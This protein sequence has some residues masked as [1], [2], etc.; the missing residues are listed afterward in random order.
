MRI[1]TVRQVEWLTVN[2][3]T[4]EGVLPSRSTLFNF[5]LSHCQDHKLDPVNAASFG[6]LIRGIF[7]GL[8]T[9]WLGTRY[10]HCLS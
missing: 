1:I 10:F 9:R 7:V 6:R 5:Y 2:Y 8:R 4:A 3:E